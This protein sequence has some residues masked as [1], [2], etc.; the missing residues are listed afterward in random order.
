MQ[1]S[2]KTDFPGLVQILK[3]LPDKIQKRVLVPALKDVS[4]IGRTQAI[5]NI[6][7][8]FN[9]DRATVS[10]SFNIKVEK[11]PSSKPTGIAYSAALIAS[12]GNRRAF[13]VVRFIE[14]KTTIAT[15]RRRSKN[16]TQNQLHIKVLKSGPFKSLGK[17][18]FLGNKGRTVFRRIPGTKKIEPIS[19]IGISQMFSARRIN[20]P[21]AEKMK[22]SLLRYID[23]SL[24]RILKNIKSA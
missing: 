3:Q 21:V 4:K 5:R 24:V 13:N 8:E 2:L 22:D 23:Y 19:T 17:N 9:I 10:S 6:T 7:R 16:S 12:S 1:I 18:A 14:K 11:V 20:E 15:A